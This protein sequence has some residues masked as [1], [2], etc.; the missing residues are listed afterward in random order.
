MSKR[1]IQTEFTEKNK[2]NGN[3]RADSHLVTTVREIEKLG[4]ITLIRRFFFIYFS[5]RKMKNR[6]FHRLCSIVY[7]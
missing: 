5:K 4:K 1:R 7:N 2:R 6:K 3:V